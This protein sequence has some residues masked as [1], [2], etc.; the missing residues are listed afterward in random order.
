[1]RAWRRSICGSARN[2]ASRLTWRT[3]V[4]VRQLARLDRTGVVADLHVDGI[5]IGRRRVELCA[6]PLTVGSQ[7]R[8]P[9]VLVAVAG[10][11][12]LG[13]AAHLADWHACRSQ[14][15]NQLDPA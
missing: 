7:E 10:A 14:L 6:D 8:E 3:E 12:Q 13:V 4:A 1:M 2:S 15:G 11:H 5:E 9:L